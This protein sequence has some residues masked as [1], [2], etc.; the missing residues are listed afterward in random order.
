M[1]TNR[2]GSGRP[3]VRRFLLPI[4]ALATASANADSATVPVALTNFH[5]EPSTIYLKAGEPVTLRLVNRSSSGHDF[6][7][8]AF[9]AAARVAPEEGEFVDDG[10]IALRGGETRD[11]H[12]TPAAG[13][14][15]LKCSHFLH[16][17]MGM[18]G[19]IVVE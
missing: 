5:F 2:N 17:P 4:L 1:R 9:F 7:A 3:P 15:K 13:R 11:V 19:T 8:P 12:L 14:Y 16:K 18:A 6:T 10:S